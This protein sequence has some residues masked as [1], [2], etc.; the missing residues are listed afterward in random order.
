MFTELVSLLSEYSAVPAKGVEP[1]GELLADVRYP[2]ESTLHNWSINSIRL[3][4]V[5]LC[6]PTSLCI[7]LS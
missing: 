5:R 6:S 3:R 1:A 4:S 2:H 7:N